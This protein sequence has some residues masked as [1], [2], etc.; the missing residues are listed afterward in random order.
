LS[1]VTL[2]QIVLYWNNWVIQHARYLMVKFHLYN[3]ENRAFLGLLSQSYYLWWW[4][5]YS[6]CLN[7]KSPLYILLLGKLPTQF[8]VDNI[9]YY[10]YNLMLLIDCLW[11]S[12]CNY[13]FNTLTCPTN[14][15]RKTYLKCVLFCCPT[16]ILYFSCTTGNISQN[17]TLKFKTREKWGKKAIAHQN[18]NLLTWKMKTINRSIKANT[19]RFLVTSHWPSKFWVKKTVLQMF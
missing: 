12:V 13:T 19:M 9:K 8:L 16:Q 3:V 15:M 5:L 10:N 14:C 6:H 2:F 11:L 18:F 4:S 7:T 1:K 17:V